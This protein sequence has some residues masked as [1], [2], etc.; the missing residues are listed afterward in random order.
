MK[1]V[2]NFVSGLVVGIANIIPGVSGG[3]MAVI[4]GVYSQLL[5]VMSLRKIRENLPF[6]LPFGAGVAL[7][8]FAFSHAIS[9]LVEAYPVQTN[10]VFL[11]L[12]LGSVPMLLRTAKEQNQQKRSPLGLCVLC[13]LG[14]LGLMLWLNS[15]TA[16]D[17]AVITQLSPSVVFYLLWTSALASFSMILPG[18]SGSFVMLLVGSYPTFLSA[19]AQLNIPLLLPIGL[20]LVLGLLLGSRLVSILLERWPLCTYLAI[21]GLILGSLVALFPGF[22]LDLS[23]I[24]SLALMAAAALFTMWFAG[25]AS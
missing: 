20:G 15:A 8:L 1:T 13:F 7:G 10:F 3:T 18:I 2:R 12:I 4:L 17:P 25:K 23:G 22:S 6:I 19:I 14:A 21:L 16:G 24:L 11:G 9:F 5:E